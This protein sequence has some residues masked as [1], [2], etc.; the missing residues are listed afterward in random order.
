MPLFAK[1]HGYHIFKYK[2]ACQ[3]VQYQ[4]YFTAGA[5]FRLKNIFPEVGEVSFCIKQP[6]GCLYQDGSILEQLFSPTCSHFRFEMFIGRSFE[7]PFVIDFTQK[8]VEFGDGGRFLYFMHKLEIERKQIADELAK[9][10][11]SKRL[12]AQRLIDTI[13]RT[14]TTKEER[15]FANGFLRKLFTRKE[16]RDYQPEDL[17]QLFTK[18][19][20]AQVNDILKQ[21][22]NG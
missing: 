20:P 8:G 4:K 6:N 21:L 15:D 16:L 22:K 13:N 1:Q 3:P 9:E 11:A 2:I 14:S 17:D 10:L 7:E 12:K 19:E 18:K 5:P